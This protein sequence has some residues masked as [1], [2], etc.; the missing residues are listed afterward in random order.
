MEKAPFDCEVPF[1]E[2]PHGTASVRTNG[3]FP[4]GLETS[5][6]IA[7]WSDFAFA[8]LPKSGGVVLGIAP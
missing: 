8:E 7:T 5:G 3:E 1:F 2:G 4:I 6:Y